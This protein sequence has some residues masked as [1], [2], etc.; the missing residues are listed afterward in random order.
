MDT[1]ARTCNGSQQSTQY[2]EFLIIKALLLTT[3][4]VPLFG[5]CPRVSLF[6]TDLIPVAMLLKKMAFPPQHHYLLAGRSETSRD[7]FPFIMKFGG[8]K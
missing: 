3:E 2:A 1:H 4:M 7:P 6:P 8:E 5:G